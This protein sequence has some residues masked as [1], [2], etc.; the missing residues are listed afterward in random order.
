LE[1]I[2]TLIVASI[3][4]AMLVQF[5]GTSMIRST[6]PVIIAQ[7]GL[8]LNQVMEMMTADYKKLLAEDPSPLRTFKGYVENGNVIGNTPYYGQYMVQAQY[9]SFEGGN[10]VKDTSGYGRILQVSISHRDMSLTALFS[11]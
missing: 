11:K 3:L 10:E 5:M 8:Y 2:I 1:I 7:N 4:G 9:V 6:E